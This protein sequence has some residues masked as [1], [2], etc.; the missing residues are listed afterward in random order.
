MFM[1]LV[2]IDATPCKIKFKI[3]GTGH[4]IEEDMDALIHVG[5]FMMMEGKLVW[6]VF[7]LED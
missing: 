7:M 1:A 2:R 3:A 4:P 6:H 5:S